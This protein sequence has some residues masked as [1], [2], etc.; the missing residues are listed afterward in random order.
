MAGG[1][2]VLRFR[3]TTR[4]PH[5]KLGPRPILRVSVVPPLAAQSR[6][7]TFM[8]YERNVWKCTGSQDVE[9]RLERKHASSLSH[10]SSSFT[11][12]HVDYGTCK[13]LSVCVSFVAVP[14]HTR[15]GTYVSGTALAAVT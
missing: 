9:W 11:C 5:V 2:C 13:G 6:V 12:V 8:S 4:A 3:R 14:V 7:M 10:R 15:N 1:F